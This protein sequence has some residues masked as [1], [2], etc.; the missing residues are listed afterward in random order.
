MRQ[1]QPPVALCAPI[2]AAPVAIPVTIEATT[3]ITELLP[4]SGK[5]ACF[6]SLHAYLAKLSF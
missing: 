4:A 6:N 5:A 1:A 3:E 2:P